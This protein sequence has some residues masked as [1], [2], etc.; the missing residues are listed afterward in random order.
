[1]SKRLQ[2]VTR[3]GAVSAVLVVALAGC[4]AAYYRTMEALGRPKREILVERVGEARDAQENVK[5]QFQTALTQFSFVVRI[6]SSQLQET[7]DDLKA[8]FDLCESRANDVSR[9]ID[10][11]GSVAEA[12]F[13]EWESELGQYTNSD[14]RRTSE[15]ELWQTREQYDELIGAMEQAEKKTTPVLGAFRDQVLFLKHNLNAQA[16]AALQEEFVSI[17]TDVAKLVQELDASIAAADRF[18]SAMAKE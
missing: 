6:P 15:Q 14:L 10:D 2:R 7:Y 5:K 9:R 17:E 3:M 12:L 13:K 1:M 16:I 4:Q 8:E 18:I 11:V